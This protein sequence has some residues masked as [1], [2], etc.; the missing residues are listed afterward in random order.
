M[1]IYAQFEFKLPTHIHTHT[2]TELKL[3]YIHTYELNQK[4]YACMHARAHTQHA[5]SK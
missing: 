3:G 2:N 4:S 1:N 5:L